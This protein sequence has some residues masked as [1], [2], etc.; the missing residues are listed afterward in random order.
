VS[1]LSLR[2]YRAERL[3]RGE[4]EGLRWRVIGAV[5]HRLR[6]T[7]SELDRCDLESCYAA[8]WQGLYMT[9]LEGSEIANPAGWLVV[10]TFRRAVDERRARTRAHRDGQRTPIGACV[11]SRG[12][13]E[14]RGTADVAD[15]RDLAAQLDDRDLLRQLFEGLRGRLS[16]REREAAVLCYLQGLTRAEAAAR[17]G[18]SEPRMRKLMEGRGP[19][20]PGV[21]GKVGALVASI[22]DGDW[23]EEQG[24]LMRALAFGVLEPRGERHK[25]AL[26]HALACP[27][28]RSY[29]AS[30]RGLAAVL[31]PVL[32]PLGLAAASLARGGELAHAGASAAGAT[33]TGAQAGAG[34]AQGTAGIVGGWGGRLGGAVSSTGA[35]GA[36]AG[37]AA[38]GG[39]MLAGGA[40]GGKL[41]LGCLV[42]LGVGA[43]CAALEGRLD[44]SPHSRR[45]DGP[46]VRADRRHAASAVGE[47][48]LLGST[49][50]GLREATPGSTPTLNARS[51]T[52][53]GRASREFGPERALAGRAP[54]GASTSSSAASA[55]QRLA[56]AAS[57]AGSETGAGREVPAGAPAGSAST[58]TSGS[59]VS[60]MSAAQ[61]AREFSPG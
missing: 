56:S 10:A 19:G 47:A 48:G 35:A 58:P 26:A 57:A 33:A 52:S 9:M 14:D 50:G 18:V 41:A 37:S 59:T 28:C 13:G 17:M 8:A 12:D 11:T 20:S 39:W 38:G 60:S 42:A 49:S 24:S 30:L 2:R 36:G 46:A 7:G 31:P 3:L 53:A 25:L 55:S 1:P 29:V 51:L 6:A 32:A 22:R 16:V 45:R 15:E 21:A 44:M 61:A 5:E 40:L 4:F 27:G 54:T 23:C 34:G 43:S